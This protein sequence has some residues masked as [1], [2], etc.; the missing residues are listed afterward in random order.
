MG[1]RITPTG[2]R[3]FV[4]E[5]TKQASL[6]SGLSYTMGDFAEAINISPQ[7]IQ[8]RFKHRNVIRVVRDCDLF[9]VRSKVS[10]CKMI[11]Y[12]GDHPD[13]KSGTKYSYVQLG[14]AFKIS[15]KLIRDRMRG[16][17]VFMDCMAITTP[18]VQ[19]IVR[20]DT[21]SS[22]TMNEWLRRKIV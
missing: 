18:G 7:T 13:L 6:I 8:S 20:C 15:E 1:K 22:K 2:K 17:R 5:G 12:D 3:M 21:R 19:T 14:K 4:Y 9:Q 16:S 10:R 11:E